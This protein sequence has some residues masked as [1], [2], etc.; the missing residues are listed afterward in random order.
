[1]SKS[2]TTPP[3][4]DGQLHLQLWR[5][6]PLARLIP[7]RSASVIVLDPNLGAGVMAMLGKLEWVEECCDA[8]PG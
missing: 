4:A 8:P 2:S 6:W 3:T 5:V 7:T 1:M